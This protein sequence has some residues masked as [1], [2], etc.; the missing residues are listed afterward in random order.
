MGNMEW[1]WGRVLR[2]FEN[3]FFLFLLLAAAL[4]DVLLFF[5]LWAAGFFWLFPLF[6]DTVLET[7]AGFLF[8]VELVLLAGSF[9]DIAPG[10]HPDTAL[11][12]LV[13]KP[14][15]AL[16]V[17][18]YKPDTALVYKL[19][20]APGVVIHDLASR[21][22]A[23]QKPD[24]GLFVLV[25]KPDI[26]LPVHVLLLD[27][28]LGTGKPDTEP[29]T[30]GKPKVS[31]VDK[32]D[33]APGV[34]DRPD[35]AVRVEGKPDIAP[36]KVDKPDIVPGEEDI[37]PKVE[38]KPA[39]IAAVEETLEHLVATPSN[40]NN[41]AVVGV[42]LG[43]VR[44]LPVLFSSVGSCGMTEWRLNGMREPPPWPRSSPVKDGGR[45][46]ELGLRDPF[47]DSENEDDE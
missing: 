31:E 29:G 26:A 45:E 24:I 42:S 41:P 4:P 37:A 44:P 7:V 15:T 16:D 40:T 9:P 39:D 35:N 47:L 10:V 20:T 38:F 28:A 5:L 32:L 27:I 3:W 36:G 46:K 17:L 33:I 19:D 8:D 1:G 34:V 25:D 11:D 43:V 30:G 14:D 21:L 2:A 18:V 13:Y 6:P 22:G 23:A 12:V